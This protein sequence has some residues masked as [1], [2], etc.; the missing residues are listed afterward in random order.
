MDRLP[1]NNAQVLINETKA[2]IAPGAQDYT[3]GAG[4]SAASPGLPLSFTE[5]N[6]DGEPVSEA[7]HDLDTWDSDLTVWA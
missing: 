1:Y 6:A 5:P 3:S 4:R 2:Q 7:I